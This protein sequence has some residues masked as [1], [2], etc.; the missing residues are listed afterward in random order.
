MSRGLLMVT[1]L[2][3]AM[4]GALASTA[5]AQVSCSGLP[6]FANCTAYAAGAS[7]TYNGSKYT[8]IA[9]APIPANR[10]CSPNSPYTPATDNWWA[11]NGTCSSATP[12]PTTATATATATTATA[13]R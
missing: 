12:T 2:C 11:N 3:I 7:V 10:D 9:N 1:G 5:S 13:T 8:N 4:G 6:A